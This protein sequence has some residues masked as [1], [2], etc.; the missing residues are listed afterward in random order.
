MEDAYDVTLTEEQKTVT[1]R[2]F[3]A[4]NAKEPTDGTK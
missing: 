2:T 4:A 1:V 3:A